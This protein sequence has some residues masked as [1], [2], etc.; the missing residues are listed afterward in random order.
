M[1][2]NTLASKYTVHFV[3]YNSATYMKTLTVWIDGAQH[4]IIEGNNIT[5]LGKKNYRHMPS[6]YMAL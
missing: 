2:S 5:F 3:H 4:K 6:T 1:L